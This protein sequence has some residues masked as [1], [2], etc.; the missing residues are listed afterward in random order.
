MG[1]AAGATPVPV[2]PRLPSPALSH[3]AGFGVG[4]LQPGEYRGLG[5]GWEC[6]PYHTTLVPPCCPHPAA[7]R[8]W[9]CAAW[10]S[11]LKP[12]GCHS[13]DRGFCSSFCPCGEQGTPAMMS[14]AGVSPA[15]QGWG[16]AAVTGCH[17]LLLFPQ[18]LEFLALACHRYFQV[19]SPAQSLHSPPSTGTWPRPGGSQRAWGGLAGGGGR[20]MWVPGGC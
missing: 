9:A 2:P 20:A 6:G 10:E 16:G 18:E 15:R 13:G 8:C 17:W 5:L 11:T 4:G 12:D 19:P 7:T 1:R 14:P 3:P